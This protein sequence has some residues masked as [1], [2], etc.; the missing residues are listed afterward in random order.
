MRWNLWSRFYAPGLTFLVV[1]RNTTRDTQKAK[2]VV[3]AV[4][5][6]GLVKA[7]GD[8]ELYK[9]DLFDKYRV[10]V[11]ICCVQGVLQSRR[12]QLGPNFSRIM[13]SSGNIA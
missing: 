2:I 1:P 7:T 4:R 11:E 6:H 12:L 9:M 8:A 3:D 13:Q 5:E 10:L